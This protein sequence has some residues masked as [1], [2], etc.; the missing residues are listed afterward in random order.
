M[1]FNFF[2]RDCT[3]ICN[4]CP[5]SIA[6]TINSMIKLMFQWRYFL[7]F[8]FPLFCCSIS[9]SLCLY[10]FPQWNNFHSQ[11]SVWR[12]FVFS[13][14]STPKAFSLSFFFYFVCRK[15]IYKSRLFRCWLWFV[16][17]CVRTSI[18]QLQSIT[19]Y[20]CWPS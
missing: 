17:A 11:N 12:R 19:L 2:S 7:Y 6:N 15:K 1:D 13:L 16:S 9:L 14:V 20:Y 3:R 5:T 8:F 4:I 18:I 10:N